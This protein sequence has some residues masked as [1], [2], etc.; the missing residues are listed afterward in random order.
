M[1]TGRRKHL[2]RVGEHAPPFRLQDLEGAGVALEDLL[3][4]GPVLLAFFKI[5]C[6]VCQLELPFLDRLWRE[7]AGALAVYGISQDDAEWTRDFNKRYG[8]T[9]PVLLD[10]AAERYPASNAC[11]ISIVP[12]VFLVERDGAVAWALEG[13]HKRE[14]QAV[15]GRFGVNPFR[16]GEYVPEAKAG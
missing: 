2:L 3:P 4:N 1:G 9:F 7:A 6:P 13:F 8:V 15:A 11:G 12:S 16:S 5:T 14:I 10:S